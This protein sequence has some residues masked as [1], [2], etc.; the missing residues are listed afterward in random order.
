MSTVPCI[1]FETC[2][3]H[4][5]DSI[6]ISQD[7]LATVGQEVKKVFSTSGF[8]YL[9]NHGIDGAL[10]TD[11]MT[12]ARE[13]FEQ[14]IENKRQ[15]AIDKD[16]NNGWL[17]TDGESINVERPADLK[18]SFN[19]TPESEYIVWPSVNKF[20]ELSKKLFKECTALSYRFLDVL[21]S[22]LNCPPDYMRGAH[23]FIGQKG[24]ISGLRALYYP[25]ITTGSI[26]K[27]NQI[28]L[29]EHDDYGTISFIF[30]DDVG[31]L[32]VYCPGVGYIPATP[33]PG[34]ILVIVAALLQRWTS[35][36]FPAPM[37]RVMIP[38]EERKREVVRQSIA[39][40]VNPDDNFIVSC[41]DGSD[42]YEP[43]RSV[44]YLNYRVQR[45]YV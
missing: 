41:L 38:E 6:K 36:L 34:T 10:V 33:V 32:E 3:L 29:G 45:T 42:K 21:S 2:G 14:P 15:C 12:A 20:Q 39:F 4:V 23:K 22:A 5:K 28:R 8:C 18:E 35:D 25:V 44:D 17:G 1:D 9:K 16:I 40:F 43:I 26:I 13:F 19:Y 30:Q 7:V 24:N 11:Y 31:G 27:L 37:H